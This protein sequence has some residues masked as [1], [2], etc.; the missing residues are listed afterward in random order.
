MVRARVLAWLLALAA[1]AAGDRAWCAGQES[2]TEGRTNRRIVVFDPAVSQ[3]GRQK[4]V[5]DMGGTVVRTLDF[6]NA[7]VVE[8]PP[9][10]L[11]SIE[12]D[13]KK[14]P[15]VVR[16]E[17]DLFLKW[18]EGV[19]GSFRD[20]PL[21][22]LDQ[23]WEEIPRPSLRPQAPGEE[24]PGDEEGEV[25][26]GVKRVNA[27]AAWPA[28]EGSGAKVAVVDTGVDYNHPDLKANI[29]GGA[30]VRD[31]AEDPKDFM[32]GHGHG[33]H[34]S[35]IVAAVRDDKGVVGVAPKAAIYGVRVLDGQG[36]GYFS[37][38]IAGISW[39]A[40]NK[41]HVINMS[42]GGSQGTITLHEAI[43]KA[44]EAG[45]TIVAAAGNSGPGAGVSY[46]ARYDECIAV[47]A[48]GPDDS[49]TSW[50]S[51]GPEVDFIAPG[52]KIPSTIKN[53]GYA[54]WSGTSMATPH[55]A[56][57][58]ALAVSKGAGNPNSVRAALVGAATALPGL[59]PKDQG[60]GM[61]DAGKLVQ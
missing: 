34:V 40:K 7:L 17:E 45:V 22:T 42:L 9:Q 5:L 2:S 54:S 14:R 1:G 8:A 26:W 41:M 37:D 52:L 36:R 18:I 39:A 21:P 46:P 32:D 24:N 15:E 53:G 30:D 29:A 11:D 38:I 60:S 16:V 19:P 44:V 57:L 50:S 25:K 35:G 3:V 28:T 55:V 59:E 10:V 58:A 33:T 47:S 20:I 12:T 56:G 4:I 23:V 49:I 61:I 43:I 31:G 27:A 51:R 6:V 13:L 48:S